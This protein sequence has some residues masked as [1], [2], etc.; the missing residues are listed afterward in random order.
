MSG[1]TS[2][3]RLTQT[4]GYPRIGKEREVK[5]ALEGYWKGTVAADALM[6]TFWTVAEA[7]WRSQA[8]AGIDRIGVGS[9]TLYDQMLDWTVRFGLIPERFQGLEGLDRYFAMARGVPGIPA[10]E[11][12]K[13]FDTNYHYLVPELSTAI[14]PEAAYGDFIQLVKRARAIVGDRA[15]PIVIGPVTL[16]SLSR[17]DGD[18]GVAIAALLPLYAE[19]LRELAELGVDEVQLHEPVLVRSGAGAS[20]GHFDAAYSLL[21]GLGLSLNLVTY[22][23]DLGKAYPWIVELPV[24]VISLDF[25]R[26][27]NLSLIQHHGWPSGKALVAGVV[28]ARSVWRGRAKETE[29]LLSELEAAL[30]ESARDAMRLA[31]SAS[32]QFVPY[33]ASR[34]TELPDALRGVFAF[35]EEKLKELRAVADGEFAGMQAAWAAFRAFSPNNAAVRERV[36]KLTDSDVS[37][38]LPYAERRTQQVALPAFPTTTIGSFPQTLSVRQLRARFRRSEITEAEYQAGVDAF[39]AYAVGV[40]DGLG[41][42]ML[43]HGEFERTDMVEYFAQKLAGFAFTRYGWVQSFGS[44]YV[45]PP[46]IFGDVTRPSPMTVR[47][48]AVAQSYTDKPVKGMLTGPVTIINWSYPRTDIPRQE[49]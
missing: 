45:R 38:A 44:R 41:L 47:E 18:M 24:D 23:D 22:F 30:P 43:V 13:W 14:S 21:A 32:L 31:S 16:L 26:G 5:R 36:A 37:R 12:T 33:A 1:H 4:V 3:K 27:D 20:R 9:A 28:D 11:M 19:L 10:L 6:D 49:I 7:S 48:F 17:F 46:I 42:D 34:E 15:V 40:Q 8:D 35:A 2:A 25:T 29:T 39:I